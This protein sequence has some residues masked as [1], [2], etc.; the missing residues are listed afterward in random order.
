M[1][2]HGLITKSLQKK[3]NKEMQIDDSELIQQKHTENTDQ[4]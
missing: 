1:K 3:W 2:R 4:S